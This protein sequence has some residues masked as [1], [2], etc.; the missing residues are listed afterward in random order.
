MRSSLEAGVSY[1][2][3]VTKHQLSID[4][5]GQY[6]GV[7]EPETLEDALS[8]IAAYRRSMD[9]FQ[10]SNAACYE[11]INRLTRE[12]AELTETVYSEINNKR[13]E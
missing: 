7:V 13:G 5:V 8:L 11:V 1:S 6:T 9:M 2:N 10:R 3:R 12:L 4:E